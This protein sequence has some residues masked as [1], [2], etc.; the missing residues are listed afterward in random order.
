SGRQEYW[1]KM[2]DALGG[3]D[4]SMGRMVKTNA[5]NISLEMAAQGLGVTVALTSL[6][7]L[8]VQRGLLAE[9]FEA[10]PLSP[11]TYYIAK[12]RVA[13]NVVVDRLLSH[14]LNWAPARSC[15]AAVR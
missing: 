4:L 9:P 3:E 13:R 2:G 1:T 10:R 15:D 8:Y 11:W 7:N 5:S 6:S 12:R 14:I